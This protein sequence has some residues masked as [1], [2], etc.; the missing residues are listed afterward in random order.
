M[1]NRS[2]CYLF[3]ITVILDEERLPSVAKIIASTGCG[4][5]HMPN[6]PISPKPQIGNKKSLE[7]LSIESHNSSIEVDFNQL[8]SDPKPTNGTL[9]Y[10]NGNNR[11]WMMIYMHHERIV[12]IDPEC[13][14]FILCHFPW[15]YFLQLLHHQP[16]CTPTIILWSKLGLVGS[17]RN[18][19][20]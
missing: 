15:V 9:Y 11:G 20:P 13:K 6:T 2:R 4:E 3:Y 1:A 7:G 8:W 17:T 14:L 10:Y 19:K 12:D 16:K 5:Y 18:P